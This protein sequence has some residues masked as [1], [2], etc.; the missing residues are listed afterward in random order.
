[1]KSLRRNAI[2]N[3]IRSLLSFLFPL[4]SYG[5]ASRTVGVEYIGRV[6]YTLAI[7]SYFSLLAVFGMNS[8]AVRECAGIR[9]DRDRI[10][11]V[12]SRY[13]A[14]NILTLVMSL[15][16]LSLC[17]FIFIPWHAYLSLFLIQSL[18]I[19][20]TVMSMEW[21]NVIYE[22]Y[23]YITL[24][25]LFINILNL[26]LLFLLVKSPED[27][28]FYAFLSVLTPVVTGIINFCYIRRYVTVRMPG[29]PDMFRD[30]RHML[31]DLWP[32]FINDLSVAVYVGADMII[33]GAMKGDYHVGIYSAA[34]KIYTIVKSVFI[35]VFSV[36][37]PRLSYHYGRGESEEFEKILSRTVSVFIILGFPAMTGLIMYAPDIISIVS[38]PDYIDAATPLRLLAMALIFAIFG[39]IATGCVNVPC[40]YERVNSR[41][42]II[43]A[44]ENTVLN[45]P[46]IYLWNETGAA[47]TTVLAE[48]T[49]LTICLIH[50]RKTGCPYR[51]ADRN[52]SGPALISRKDLRDTL[53]GVAML[54]VI[55][56][57]C[58]WGIADHMIR[59]IIGIGVSVILYPL[60]FIILGNAVVKGIIR[61]RSL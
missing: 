57:I 11:S 41:A 30:F 22:D 39:G 31:H 44:L 46:A 24:R 47:A 10:S 56:M 25:G 52:E 9:D 3:T 5:Y 58:E 27:Y 33:L 26:I 50:Y 59:A 20:F 36:M 19:M 49:V 61:D 7:I 40:G 54:V 60:V 34:V 6:Q 48:A 17:V 45:I 53:I 8:Y 28:L 13:L 35:A 51:S 32:F 1:M 15:A 37:V 2:F 38:G 29:L 4:I 21:I 18:S 14:F 43:A 12:A 42:T 23:G 16:A 55:R